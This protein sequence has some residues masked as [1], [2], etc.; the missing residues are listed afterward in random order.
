M[1]SPYLLEK[2]VAERLGISQNALAA[3]R[4]AGKAPRHTVIGRAIRYFKD[5]V[6]H[7][8]AGR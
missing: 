8:V 2:E 3:R 4:R 5:D 1:Q 6:D 7:V